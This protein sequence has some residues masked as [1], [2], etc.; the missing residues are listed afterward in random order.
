MGNREALRRQ[1]EAI[2]RH[3]SLLSIKTRERYREA[4][5]RFADWLA[6]ATDLQSFCELKA[7][8]VRRYA[9]AMLSEG[10]CGAYCLTAK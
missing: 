3:D 6:G 9:E 4:C 2:F 7:D 5:L 10:C 1:A 8:H